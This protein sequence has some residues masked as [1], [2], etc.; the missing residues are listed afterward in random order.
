MNGEVHM[1]KI[2][3]KILTVAGALLF[4][5]ALLILFTT[6][7]MAKRHNDSIMS[8]RAAAGLNVLKNDINVQLERLAEISE[9][10][11]VISAAVADIS[12]HIESTSANAGRANGLSAQSAASCEELSGMAGELK[13]QIGQLRA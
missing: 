11:A 5:M 9:Q 4:A 3:R 10:Q 7:T 12:G 8:E 1:S 6:V 2:S 13:R